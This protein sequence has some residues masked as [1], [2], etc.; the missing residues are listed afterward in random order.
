M[1]D[2]RYTEE[3]NVENNKSKKFNDYSSSFRNNA[4]IFLSFSSI[5]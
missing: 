2:I 1:I 3:I 5:Y 4:I